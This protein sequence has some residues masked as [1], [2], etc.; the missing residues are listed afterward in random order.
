MFITL[1][2]ALAS[3]SFPFCHCSSQ[4][5][6]LRG[7]EILA[8]NENV[9]S[10]CLLVRIRGLCAISG[11]RSL[12]VGRQGGAQ[13]GKGL[14]NLKC[15]FLT[16]KLWCQL[17]FSCPRAHEVFVLFFCR[18]CF[19]VC[20]MADV[21]ARANMC[22]CVCLCERETAMISMSE[23]TAC[24]S[25]CFC[26]CCCVP[27][28]LFVCVR[29]CVCMSVCVCQWTHKISSMYLDLTDV[30]GCTVIYSL[31]Q[32]PCL[33]SPVFLLLRR[34]DGINP[35]VALFTKDR[36]HKIHRTHPL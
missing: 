3:E 33:L 4:D 9:L 24:L 34:S 11:T 19:R 32:S 28:C 6:R 35:P 21:R 18:F 36:P 2:R 15:P 8:A 7:W 31:D 27:V 22:V 5:T 30:R 20:T 10:R 1:L 25:V 16:P 12:K 14:Y 13:P 17:V 26:L 23:L 29:V